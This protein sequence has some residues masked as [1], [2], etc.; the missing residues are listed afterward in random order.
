MHQ[1]CTTDGSNRSSIRLFPLHITLRQGL[2]EPILAHRHRLDVEGDVFD[3]PLETLSQGQLKKVDL[4]RTFMSP[5]HLLLWDE[6]LN[7]VDILSREQIEQ[8]VLDYQAIL[9]GGESNGVRLLSPKTI[10]LMITNH[11]GDKSIYIKGPGY[12]FGLG[13]SVLTDPGKAAEPLTPGSF[14]W[15]GAWGTLCWADPSFTRCIGAFHAHRPD[16]P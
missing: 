14:S 7:Y 16:L 15:G 3:Q 8:V 13:Y 11:T 5:A 12:G 2:R 10:N 9:N 6:P 4:S 1:E